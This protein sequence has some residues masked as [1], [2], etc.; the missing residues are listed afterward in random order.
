MTKWREKKGNKGTSKHRK[1]KI[2]IENKNKEICV[3]VVIG[4]AK[5]IKGII[6]IKKIH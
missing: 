3:R 2:Y 5:L 1:K 4:I 6:G